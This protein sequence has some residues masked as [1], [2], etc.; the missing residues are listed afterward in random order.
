M[1]LPQKRKPG[2]RP[3]GKGKLIGLRLQPAPLSALDAF[4]ADQRE[5]ISRL[6]AIRVI[7]T[8]FLRSRGYLPKTSGQ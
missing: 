7:L 6:E 3:T 8:Q 4:V 2:P 1:M 5:P